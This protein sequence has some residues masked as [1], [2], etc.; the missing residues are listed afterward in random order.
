LFAVLGSKVIAVSMANIMACACWSSSLSM[1]DH[2]AA[3][4]V[5]DRLMPAQRPVT[6]A[7]KALGQRKCLVGLAG[8][9]ESADGKSKIHR[10]RPRRVYRQATQER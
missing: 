3:I 9:F 4:P 8:L 6:G 2:C 5:A 10:R 1:L 7:A